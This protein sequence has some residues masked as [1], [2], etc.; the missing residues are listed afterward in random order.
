ML[1][2]TRIP[3]LV[4]ILQ[5]ICCESEQQVINYVLYS[6][7]FTPVSPHPQCISTPEDA[8]FAASD[9]QLRTVNIAR[10]HKF[11]HCPFIKPDDSSM[12]IFHSQMDSSAY[13]ASRCDG[14]DESPVTDVWGV[15]L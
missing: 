5:I 11:R 14:A 13:S 4:F 9:L 1:F 7:L 3:F 12:Q 15:A 10:V 2:L 6:I 8:L